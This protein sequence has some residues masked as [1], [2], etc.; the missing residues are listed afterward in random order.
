MFEEEVERDP[1]AHFG[2]VLLGEQEHKGGCLL[3]EVASL[4]LPEGGAAEGEAA[5]GLAE[6][7][8]IAG[9]L[10]VLVVLAGIAP[11]HLW[12]AD[13]APVGGH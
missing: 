2:R 13:C 3:E 11:K 6:V 5:L 12:V 9:Q 8:H 10:K 4:Q 7:D 1:V